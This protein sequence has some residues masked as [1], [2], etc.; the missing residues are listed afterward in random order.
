MLILLILIFLS[1]SLNAVERNKEIADLSTPT[2]TDLRTPNGTELYGFNE[3]E[4][5]FGSYKVGDNMT[6]PSDGYNYVFYDD[7]SQTL[8]IYSIDGRVP[9]SHDNFIFTFD[10]RYNPNRA[11]TV[12]LVKN[13]ETKFNEGIYSE[14][15]LRKIE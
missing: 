15:S 5:F 8:K 9:N 6:L 11:L 3:K 7:L 14:Y 4:M 12:Y 1:I 2:L 10:R 13:V